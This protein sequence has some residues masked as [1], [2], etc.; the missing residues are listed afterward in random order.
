MAVSST[1]EAVAGASQ[2]GWPVRV[3][4]CREVQPVSPIREHVAVGQTQP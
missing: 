1:A 4:A 3:C 2:C